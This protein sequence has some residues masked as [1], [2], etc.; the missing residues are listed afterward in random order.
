MSAKKLVLLVVVL[1]V[2][3][4]SQAMADSINGYDWDEMTANEKIIY[5]VGFFEG[6]GFTLSQV[7]NRR[8]ANDDEFSDLRFSYYRR[9]YC[10]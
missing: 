2:V 1:F 10:S 8:L 4:A 6:S 9:R 5:I 3:I 7:D